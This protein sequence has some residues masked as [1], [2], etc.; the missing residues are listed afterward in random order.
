Q[1]TVFSTDP[2]YYDN[3]GYAD[4]SDFFYVWLRRSLSSVHPNIF[5]RVLTPKTEELVASPYRHGG[6]EAAE[7]HFMEGMRKTLQG[8]ASA[9][10]SSPAAIYYAYKQQEA[11]EDALTSPGWSSF[12]QAMAAS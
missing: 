1:G 8:I 9:M 10:G 3:V 7:Q 4:L 6:K 12:L 2:P 11:G 5:R